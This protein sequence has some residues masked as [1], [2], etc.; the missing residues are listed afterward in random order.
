M[1]RQPQQ[2][3]MA[4]P[5][6]SGSSSINKPPPT[7]TL[8]QAN[9][10]SA[11]QGNTATV[12]NNN[13]NNNNQMSQ[14]P[15][16]LSLVN[17]STPPKPVIVAKRVNTVAQLSSISPVSTTAG[18]PPI[19]TLSSVNVTPPNNNQ[20]KVSFLGLLKHLNLILLLFKEK[21]SQ[22]KKNYN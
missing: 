11:Y 4:T 18:K 1:I 6:T 19:T 12:I 8:T 7:L 15:T 13:N 5:S 3:T 2:V 21:K 10:I 14:Q 9:V 20:Q 22:L 16:V 17:K